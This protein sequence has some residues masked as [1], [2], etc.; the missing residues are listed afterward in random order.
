MQCTI[1]T[2]KDAQEHR[3]TQ[4]ENVEKCMRKKMLFILFFGI[5]SVNIRIYFH[6]LKKWDNDKKIL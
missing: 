3:Q 4:D 6:N 1:K 5:P 2:Y